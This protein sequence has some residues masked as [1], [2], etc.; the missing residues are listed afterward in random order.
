MRSESLPDIEARQV[1]PLVLV[2][3]DDRVTRR[4]MA[5]NLEKVGYQVVS[6]SDG[7]AALVKLQEKHF[8]FLVTDWS[9]PGK[10][11]PELCRAVR[12]MES[13]SYIY[14]LIVTAR[15][16]KGDI[17]EGLDAGADDFLCKPVDRDELLARM[18]TGN[19]ILALEQSLK[20]AYSK[21]EALSQTDVLS[22]AFN[23]RYL[24]NQLPREIAR[25]RR[26]GHALSVIICDID[27]FKKVNDT[28][29]HQVGDTVIKRFSELIMLGIRTRVD[30]VARYGGEE[31][32]VVLPEIPFKKALLIG[33]RL[34]RIVSEK[35]ITFHEGKDVHITCSFGVTGFSP[36]E[37]EGVPDADGM[38][39]AADGYLYQSKHAGRNKVLGG[40]LSCNEAP[41]CE[42]A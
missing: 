4:I 10:S 17:V 41:P 26:Y 13:D 21:I 25:A 24:M 2:A 23:R 36:Q 42:E 3:E 39:S 37:G 6:V 32:L 34:R 11:G 22:G 38:V 27:F 9:M 7:N 14:I 29:G 8:S 35:A 15:Q 1:L 30:W 19:R 20:N 12:G 28:Y 40:L 31:F 18:N 33:E 5:K 16:S